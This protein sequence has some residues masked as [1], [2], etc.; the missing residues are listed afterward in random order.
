LQSGFDANRVYTVPVPRHDD[1][2]SPDAPAQ[3]EASFLEFLKE[4]RIGGEF[5][6]RDRLRN[7]VLMQHHSLEVDL[8]DLAMYT[9][10]LAQK[11]HLRP[12]EMVPLVR[13]EMSSCVFE[14][15]ADCLA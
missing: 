13:Y 15:V 9:A 11:V 12:G 1:E 8:D 14:S 3:I 10:E 6:Y 5:V 4:F 7:A 2:M